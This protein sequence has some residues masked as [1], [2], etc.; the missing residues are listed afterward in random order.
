MAERKIRAALIQMDLAYRDPAANRA[1]ASE[2]IDKAAELSPDVVLLPETW[3]SAYSVPVFHNIK[4]YAEPIDGPSVSMLREKARRYGFNMVGGSLALAEGEVCYNAA[5]V[6]NRKGELLGK[7][8]KMHLYSAMDE[9]M[10]FTH[11]TEMP[12]W[13]FDFGKAAVMT[14]YDIRFVELSRTFALRGA[15]VI[16]VVSNFPAPKLHHWRTLLQARAI[17]NQL[18][19]VAC[20]RVG[21]AEEYTYFGHSIAIDPWGET[22]AEG[23]EK[24]Q[25]IPVE[26]DLDAVDVVRSR[27]PMFYDRRPLSYPDDFQKPG[28]PADYKWPSR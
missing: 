18:F 9:D 16:F 1:K 24:E 28:L 3:T 10:A 2:L 22:I 4:A 23:G 26:I 19:V 25:I 7:Y 20:N 6:I 15:K 17:E 27:I 11:G 13:E 14:C 21:S 8:C 12:V 5:P